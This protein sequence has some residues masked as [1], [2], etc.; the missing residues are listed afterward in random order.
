VAISDIH[1]NQDVLNLPEGDL[2]LVAG[3]MTDTASYKELSAFSSFLT[4]QKDKFRK[5]IIVPGNHEITFDEKFYLKSGERYHKPLLD[6]KKAKELLL[7]NPNITYLEDS[8]CEFEGVKIWG[9]P[10]IP[11]IG[12]WA[13]SLPNS[14]FAKEIFGKIPED[15][16]ILI[17]HAPPFGVLD[18]VSHKGYEV[19]QKT[20][21]RVVIIDRESMGSKE[22]RQRVMEV[23]P[24][25]HVFGHVHEG[26]GQCQIDGI[27]FANV[28]IMTKE[29]KPENK[30]K[31]I[32]IGFV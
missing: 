25:L 28:A 20:G 11:P 16:D 18:E 2:L 27:L 15:T 9:T 24:K 30:P 19:D 6:N 4:N 17:S 31:L 32:E 13:F 1:N 3:D 8:G 10:W 29:H 21:K 7:S 14:K 5:I 12:K 23:R 22:L 26:N